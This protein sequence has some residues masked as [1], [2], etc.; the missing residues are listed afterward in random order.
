MKITFWEKL[1]CRIGLMKIE[2]YEY[3]FDLESGTTKTIR[4]EVY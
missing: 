4:K 1:L 3:E 2:I